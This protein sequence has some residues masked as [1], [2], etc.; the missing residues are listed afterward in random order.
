MMNWINYLVSLFVK[1]PQHKQAATYSMIA[2]KGSEVVWKRYDTSIVT[3][4]NEDLE[5]F[6]TVFGEMHLRL[7]RTTFTNCHPGRL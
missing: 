1:K 7:E 3:K 2:G 6:A 5:I 4:M